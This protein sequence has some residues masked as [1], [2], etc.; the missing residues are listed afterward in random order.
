MSR[1]TLSLRRCC[2]RLL[3]APG[4]APVWF[5]IGTVFAGQLPGEPLHDRLWLVA[6]LFL[7]FL[8]G[9]I[10]EGTR[11]NGTLD[12]LDRLAALEP[13]RVVVTLDVDGY[14]PGE[15]ATA[16]ADGAL[17]LRREQRR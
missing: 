10:H 7:A 13:D 17:V 12:L 1:R 16:I 2:R 14:R 9:T 5:L 6:L 8:A 3:H 11:K 15:L 4:P